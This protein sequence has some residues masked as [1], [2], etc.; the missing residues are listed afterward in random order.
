[1]TSRRNQPA[2]LEPAYSLI[3]KFGGPERSFSAGVKAV[4]EI[5]QVDPS[6]VYR[7][8]MS[9]DRGGRGG[10]VPTARQ[11]RLFEYAKR[12]RLPVEPGDFFGVAAA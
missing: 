3:C 2:Y 6:R 5:A 1:M 4:A 12:K 11:Q 10:L 9:K 7:W 8:A